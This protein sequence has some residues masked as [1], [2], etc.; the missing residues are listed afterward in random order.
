[1][2]SG[3]WNFYKVMAIDSSDYVKYIYIKGWVPWD[4]LMGM[5]G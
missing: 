1:M 5:G 3:G 4:G 2:T